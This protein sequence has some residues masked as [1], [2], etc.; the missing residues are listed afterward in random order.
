[1][2]K[3]VLDTNLLIDASSDDYNSSNKIIDEVLDGK[4]AA[5]ANRQT[6]AENRLMARRKISDIRYLDKLEDFFNCVHIVETREYLDV[7]EDPDDN[8]I[9]ESA[10]EA[11]VDFLVT[12]D[13]HLLKLQKFEEIMILP[14]ANFWQI[15]QEETGSGWKNWLNQFIN[16]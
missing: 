13:K 9:L 14:P 10:V 5:F 8:K 7:V 11:R 1:M 2:F 12:S 16:N 4:L 15:Y 6:L 3:I